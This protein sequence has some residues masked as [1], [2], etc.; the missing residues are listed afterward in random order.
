MPGVPAR[1]IVPV[2][3]GV[4][5]R[6]E[7]L[8]PGEGVPM[9]PPTIVV[10]AAVVERDGCFLVTRRLEGTHLAGSWE[11]PG[12]KCE[13]G[14][15]DEECLARELEEELGVEARIGDRL[16]AVR[17][18]YEHRVVDLRFYACEIE[19]EPLPLLGQQMRWVPRDELASLEL[20]PADA[21]LI[22]LLTNRT[23]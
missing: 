23:L 11:F 9:T 13:P 21:E 16:F 7:R 6:G 10:A 5:A 12:G 1:T 20:P 2:C 19:G 22:E 17:H 18:A 14:E 3:R 4:R 8:A 15:S